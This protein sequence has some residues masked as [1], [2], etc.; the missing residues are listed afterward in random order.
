[1]RPIVCASLAVVM[2]VTWARRAE[3]L[4][5]GTIAPC[6]VGFPGDFDVDGD[7]DGDDFGE[8][9]L[10]AT[11]PAQG[12]VASGCEPTDM[13]GDDDT[14]QSDFGLWQVLLTGPC[15]CPPLIAEPPGGLPPN[16]LRS[17]Y[18]FSG[19]FYESAADLAIAGRGIGFVWTRKY[20]SRIGPDTEAGRGWDYGYN[21][22][23]EAVG[24]H[25]RLYDGNT[26]RDVYRL[27]SDGTWRRPEFFNALSQN[28]DDSFTL[29]FPDKGAWHF[30]PLDGSPAEGRIASVADRYGNALT[31][32]YDAAGRL[33]TIHDSLDTPAHNRDI[34]IAYD[35]DGR[36]ASVTDFIGRQVTYAYYDG[37]EPG[38]NAGDL[39][40]VT[41]PAVVGTPTGN[42]FPAGKT[43][44]Y[45]YSTGFADDR[46]NHNLLTITDPKGQTF[47]QNG[48]SQATNPGDP[49]FDRLIEQV[50]AGPD[51]ELP[52]EEDS[53][54]YVVDVP[55]NPG[56]SNNFAVTLAIVND[57]VGNVE[58][59]YFD[60]RHRCV[61]IRE[62]TGRADPDQP[63]T[64]S[65]NLPQNPLRPTDPPF[66]ETRFSYNADSLLTLI[67]D[68]NGNEEQFFYDVANPD[69]SSRG[70]LLQHCVLP[71]PLG[72][73][74]GVICEAFEYDPL[75]NFGTNQL[76]R[77]IDARFNETLYQYD[78]A[79]NHV[80]TTHRVP[81]IVEDFEHN[82]FGQLTAH[83]HP[84][85]GTGHRRR[86][87]FTYYAAGPSLGYLHQAII[88]TGAGLTNLTTTYEYDAVGNVTRVIDPRGNDTLYTY[89]ALDQLVQRR[90]REAVLPAKPPYDSW[91]Y[92]DANDNPVRIDAE[93]RDET[94]ALQ[95]NDRLTTLY[96]YDVLDR[97]TR[98]C[99]ESGEHD[100]S[101]APPQLDCAGLP[102]G[103]FV[104]TEYEYDDN[105]NLTRVRSPEAVENRQPDNVV[106]Y[107]YDERDLV[108]Q[109]IRAPGS[110]DESTTRYA[111]DGNR[112]FFLV[113]SG[114]EDPAS[115]RTTQ[116]QHDGYD[117]LATATDPMGNVA[118][119]HYDA[120][121]NVVSSRTDGELNDQPGG[122]GNVRLSQFAYAYDVMDR[123]F[124]IDESFFNPQTQ[125][126]IGD[127]RNRT[128][129][130]YSSNSQ[131]PTVTDDNNRVTTYAYDTV[132]RLRTVTDA[133]AN[134]VTYTY[135]PS[136]NLT[137]VTETAKSDLGTPDET[138]VTTYA[139]DGHDRLT[140]VTDS[141]GNATAYEYDSRDNVVIT[142]DAVGHGAR[143]HYDGMNR[144]T[145]TVIDMDGDGPDGDGDD[146]TTAQAW[147]DNSR[148]VQKTDDNGHV[149]T[150]AYDA[151]NRGINETLPDTTLHTSVYDVHDNVVQETDP[152]ATVVT[153][154]HD[155][156]DRLTHA[157]IAV[158]PGVSNATTFESFE[159]DGLGRMTEAEDDD[160]LAT[161]VWDSRS[162]LGSQTLNGQTT[163]A[164]YDG[165]GNRLTCTYP[166]GRQITYTYDALNRTAS[167]REGVD[168]IVD[169]SYVG[170]DRVARRQFGNGAS[171]DYAYDGIQG[172]PNPQG[173]FGVKRVIGT[174][175]TSGPA[176]IDARTY[177]WDQLYR[178]T[179]RADVLA[180]G[181][182]ETHVYGYDYLHRLTRGRKNDSFGATVRDTIYNLD[183]AG[184][185]LS[186]EGFGGPTGPYLLDPT[187]P[188]PADAQVNQY[189][190]THADA[191]EYDGNGNL[192]GVFSPLAPPRQIAYDY[193]DRVV[194]HTDLGTGDA[195]T[196]RYD[197]L[198]RRTA[199]IVTPSGL[200]PVETRYSY[201]MGWWGKCHN[202]VEEQDDTGTTQATY[203]VK[204][205]DSTRRYVL[206][207]MRRG[208]T[209]YYYHCDDLG[210]VMAVTDETGAVV[211]RY[212][213]EDFGKPAFFDG[214]GAP[215]AGSAIGNPYLF[216][217]Q[218]YDAET[219]WYSFPARYLDP[220]T[221]RFVTRDPIGTWT[222]TSALGNGY[223]YAGNSPWTNTD[224]T[225][226]LS[227]DGLPP[228]ELDVGCIC[229]LSYDS[230]HIWS[231]SDTRCRCRGGKGGGGGVRSK[232]LFVGGLSWGSPSSGGGGGPLG[233][234]GRGTVATGRIE[235]GIAGTGDP[236]KEESHFVEVSGLDVFI[237]QIEYLEG[238][239]LVPRKAPSVQNQ[240]DW[241]K[242]MGVV[243]DSGSSV[244][245]MQNGVNPGIGGGDRYGRVKVQ[246]HWGREG[247][248]DSNSSCWMRVV[249]KYGGVDLSEGTG[250]M[251]IGPMSGNIIA[252]FE[253]IQ[254]RPAGY[255]GGGKSSKTGSRAWVI[256]ESSVLR[257]RARNGF[258]GGFD[259][260][261]G[262]YV[263]RAGARSPMVGAGG[264]SAIVLDDPFRLASNR[265]RREL[266][267][268][269]ERK[270]GGF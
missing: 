245:A 152:N 105:G 144:P 173:D 128:T 139:Y 256:D 8:F 45:T 210:N 224:P 213:Y 40:S 119:Y 154:T 37:V 246:F 13:D 223:T 69:P 113:V 214:A 49:D 262:R 98:S 132:N 14:D 6:D 120:N 145:Q 269:R 34:V 264:L 208:G 118:T 153:F 233:I 44:T 75:V 24:P 79:G 170:P 18:L 131:V 234:G 219:G 121:G 150:Y 266:A 84:D 29:T 186:L 115:P 209:D 179:Q 255:G 92:Y 188:Q 36:V 196:Y 43:T 147:D 51:E 73:D 16:P 59:H 99:V 187:L 80:H 107:I 48:Y 177:T 28:P 27:Q 156:L 64:P 15:D 70:N 148:V 248:K 130:S 229:F 103:E 204:F 4:C 215:L 225:G 61:M 122:A 104:T 243:G 165:V 42:D 270:G 226:L 146:I 232:K 163:S 22:R 267:I 227:L 249:Q 57:R 74:Q 23:V 31:F 200:P 195:V 100:V 193:A 94:G 257:L 161:F 241:N 176:M 191:R 184:N 261:S 25:L 216:T 207:S 244:L 7:V 39:K 221:G 137:A 141:V 228:G 162:D 125:A 203:V 167:V 240:S 192:L 47:V 111:Y 247:K 160:S 21:M 135:D 151:L 239:P 265:L 185:R 55:Q 222:D 250:I 32:E 169:F 68:P 12:P 178:K 238:G 190:Q 9:Q 180:G 206:H 231:W 258:T 140:Q 183:G 212:E 96:E 108:F 52:T 1:M 235:T 134:A 46:L 197:T 136:S 202:V 157:S 252:D 101:L 35:A 127:G 82:P 88:D 63:T 106:Q 62:Y 19:E 251:V 71:G 93:N 198:G 2:S 194:S 254:A 97:L 230:S 189:T 86:D 83:V 85:N 110:A 65:T 58:E 172:V 133:K 67:L 26:R 155:L 117:R 33:V 199:K 242:V 236:L 3:A 171:A 205:D 217:G 81:S 114:F 218:R 53:I 138:F 168:T 102:A 181:P 41:T 164:T 175:H 50:W 38:G 149:T 253:G 60:E 77:H 91:F 109:R 129:V 5:P 159:Y 143:R 211:E 158:G 123:V 90:A 259:S 126:P 166:G 220:E 116:Y 89:N 56:P 76:T 11:G 54:I 237:D 142:I 201:D 87:A 268:E 182:Q 72:G 95:A 78:P 260:S 66:Y 263:L 30:N 112:S 174:T 124:R 10:C 17:T 20:R